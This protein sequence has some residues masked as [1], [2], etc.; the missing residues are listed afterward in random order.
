MQFNSFEHQLDEKEEEEEA[1]NTQN[2]CLLKEFFR[3]IDR[4][5]TFYKS[6]QFAGLKTFRSSTK[7]SNCAHNST[8]H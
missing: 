3:H 4:S 6:T 5:N 1:E 7:P 2:F 8:R